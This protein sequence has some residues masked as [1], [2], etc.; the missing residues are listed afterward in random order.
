MAAVVEVSTVS[1][2]RWT[3]STVSYKATLREMVDAVT[4]LE[5][6]DMGVVG[7][8]STPEILLWSRSQIVT[9]A[10]TAPV[11]GVVPNISGTEDRVAAAEAFTV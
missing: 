3:S 8:A 7:R 1:L 6:V 10:A 4:S 5:M 11:V 9:L 2:H